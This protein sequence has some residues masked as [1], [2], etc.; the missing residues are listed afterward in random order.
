M[1]TLLVMI[2]LAG[3]VAANAESFQEAPHPQDIVLKAKGFVKHTFCAEQDGALPLV[4]VW[5]NYD[6]GDVAGNARLIFKTMTDSGRVAARYTVSTVAKGVQA[7]ASV[8]QHFGAEAKIQIEE[9]VDNEDGGPQP[10]GRVL[11]I[12]PGKT[13]NSNLRGFLKKHAGV[14]SGAKQA[15]R[16]HMICFREIE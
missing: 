6:I 11:V 2:L 3:S 15:I 7:G 14:S 4:D 8:H 1:K 10:Y 13:T 5:V 16:F 12:M 9:N